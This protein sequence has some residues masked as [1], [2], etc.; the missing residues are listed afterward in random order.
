MFTTMICTME[1]LKTELPSAEERE[2]EPCHEDGEPGEGAEEDEAEEKKPQAGPAPTNAQF[3]KDPVV[4]MARFNLNNEVVKMRKEVKRV[5]ALI[6]R[7]MTRQIK[8]LKKKKGKEA[9]IERNQRRADRLLEEIQA[10]KVLPPDLVTKTALQ[11]NLN[12]NQ[13]CKNPQSTLS[14]RG[15]TRIASHPQFIKR[16]DSIKAALKAFKEG[17]IQSEDQGGKLK[18]Q[19]KTEKFPPAKERQRMKKKKELTVEMTE[20]DNTDSSLKDL[21]KAAVGNPKEERSKADH[22]A[23]TADDKN[24]EMPE[25]KKVISVKKDKAIGNVPGPIAR[26]KA[27]CNTASK[28]LQKKTEEEES[29]LELLDDGE[30]E[31]FDDS[32]EERFHRQSSESEESDDNDFFVGKVSKLKKKT[33]QNRKREEK[34]S[35]S[36]QEPSELPVVQSKPKLQTVFCSTLAASG[37]DKGASRGRGKGQHGPRVTVKSVSH[38]KSSFNK[39]PVLQKQGRGRGGVMKQ[40]VSRDGAERNQRAQTH[41]ALHPSWEASKKRKELQ[42]HIL[43][44]QGKKIKFDDDD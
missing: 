23:D 32:T 16:I 26:K 43:A 41:Q 5:R 7:K 28:V 24:Q 25:K 31:Y 27:S 20:P 19:N 42:G 3:T 17:R 2:D 37:M 6:I 18:G 34:V 35:P 12:L 33:K 13:V 8:S 39:Q 11:K 29:D 36:N 15:L 21:K 22:L 10:M 40:N 4:E 9:D 30:K 1:K 38:G 14:D 44:F